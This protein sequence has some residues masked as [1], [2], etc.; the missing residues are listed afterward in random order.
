MS[1]LIGTWILT[2][3]IGGMGTATPVLHNLYGLPDKGA[4]EVVGEATAINMRKVSPSREVRVSCVQI[5]AKL[6][7]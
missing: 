1:T 7:R 6:E 5:G 2:V 3:Y 4:C